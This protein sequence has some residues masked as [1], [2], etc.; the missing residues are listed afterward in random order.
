MIVQK[1]INKLDSKNYILSYNESKES[2]YLEETGDFIL[3]NSIYH[4]LD[5]YS[6]KVLTSFKKLSK[7]QGVLISGHKGSGKSLCGKD[8]CI[9]SNLPVLIINQPFSGDIFNSFIDSINQEVILFFDEF[10]KTY[11]DTEHQERLLTLM[12]GVYSNKILF[13]FTVNSTD[14]NEFMFN[15]PSRIRYNFKFDVIDNETLNKITDDLLEDKSFEEDIYKTVLTLGGV[16]VDL[17]VSLIEEVNLFK[18]SPIELLDDLNIRLEKSPYSYTG[19]IK[20]QYGKDINVEGTVNKSP[21][22]LKEIRFFKSWDGEGVDYREDT[23]KM[24][25]TNIGDIMYFQ[26]RLGNEIVFSP[27]KKEPGI[28]NLNRMI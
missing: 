13:I 22:S 25:I 8:I 1:K 6:N 20:D 14:I 21:L 7:N 15:R 10:E 11:K 24:K 2:F 18:K 23:N 19:K 4:D 5:Y 16:G 12:D 9:K 17:L 26:D 27:I 3:P 28:N